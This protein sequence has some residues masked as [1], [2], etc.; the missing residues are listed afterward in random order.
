[1]KNKND[2]YNFFLSDMLAAYRVSPVDCVL[3]VVRVALVVSGV[4]DDKVD[5]PC[6]FSSIVIVIGRES[7]NEDATIKVIV[8]RARG[9]MLFVEYWCWCEA[10]CSMYPL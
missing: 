1:M 8:T 10:C 9:A 7:T 4:R 2:G 6:L 3:C 5:K